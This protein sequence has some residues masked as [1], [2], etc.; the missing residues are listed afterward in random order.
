MNFKNFEDYM[1]QRNTLI[2]AAEKLLEEGKEEEYDAKYQEIQELDSAYDE[3]ARKQADI[4]ALKGAVK[5]PVL[6]AGVNS[7]P[8]V[9]DAPMDTELEYRKSFMN[10]VLKGT[11]I[12]A[13]ADETT[14]TT[15]VGVL[16]PQTVLNRIIER[17]EQHGNIL[18]KVTRT[19]YKGGVIV[20]S[21][22]IK[23]VAT[24]VAERETS[25]LQKKTVEGNITFSYYKLQMKI[26]VSIMVD[27]VTMEI[28]E[29]TLARNIAEGITSAL[30]AAIIN[31]S[32][33]GQPKGILKETAPTGQNIDIKGTFTFKD[34]CAIEAAVP[35]GYDDV[36]WCMRKSTYLTQIV[37]M[38]D[39]NG[40][41]IAR[42]N[43]GFN[44]KPEYTILGRPVEFTEE[45]PA[46]PATVAADTVIAFLFRF[47]DYMLNTNMNLRLKRYTDEGTDDEITKATMLV[48]G[49][50]I[51]KN[52]LVT[53]TLKKAA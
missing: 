3:F 11:P 9:L 17:I 37:A 13:N 35:T 25:G 48:D 14:V 36:I 29:A 50:V 5:A 40:Q 38:T 46:F 15:D 16:I 51:D 4:A 20:P 24:W 33:T 23:P 31:G 12:M 32:G 28:F 39:A 47:R 26:A 21:S 43:T 2:M 7:Q 10:H 8:A 41:P 18:A 22:N 44:G 49:K 30:E 27:N 19:S 52:S 6:A 1:A 45:M 34:L 53:V 42:I